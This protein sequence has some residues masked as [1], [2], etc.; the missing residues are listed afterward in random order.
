MD[1]K[2][3]IN[4]F[5]EHMEIEKNRAQKTLENYRRYLLHFSAFARVKNPSEITAELVRQYRVRLN[6]TQDRSGNTLK[7]NTQAYYLIALRSFLKYLAKRNI[8]SLAAEKIE[9]GKVPERKLEFLD[10]DELE[11]LLTAPSKALREGG[12]A[13]EGGDISAWRGRAILETLFSTGLRVS[14]LCSL[15]RDNVNIERG[16]FAVRGKGSKL[17]VVFLSDSAKDALKKY[18]AERRDIHEALF[19]GHHGNLNKKE[20]A[21][22][23]PRSVQRLIKKYA[24]MAGVIKKVSPHQLRHSFATDLLQNGADI[25][26]V[27]AMLGHAN[28]TTTQ[29]YTHYTDKHLK[30]IHKKY[31]SNNK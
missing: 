2:H 10:A 24:V 20:S 4:D 3:A 12:T 13:P 19:V 23:T 27:Q 15:N 26:S 18:L 31:H 14:E 1:I 29:I 17:R 21:R 6:R 8:N 5:L 16:E 11:R 28:I 30:E 9:L 22:L 7:K 25:R